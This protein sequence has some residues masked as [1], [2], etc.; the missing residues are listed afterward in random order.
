M[1]NTL[2]RTYIFILMGMI[3]LF[4]SCSK[5]HSEP[6]I[7][8]PTVN[9]IPYSVLV[10]LITPTDKSFN[11]Q[12]Y[13]AVKSCAL[14][15]QNWYKVQMNNKTFVLNPVVVDTLTGL[16][17]SV[18]YNSNN[19]LPVGGNGAYYNTLYELQQLLGAK[20]STV[21]YTYFVYVAA[22]FPDETIPKG[23]A[24]EGLGNLTGLSGK[25]PNSWIGAAGH[26]LGHAFGLPEVAIENSQ[27]IMSTGYPYYPNCIFTQPE[28]DSLNASPFFKLF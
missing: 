4:A 7:I 21:N 27:A 24:A 5:N 14:S 16:H 18:W 1:R 25:N 6:L 28:K 23:L 15:L 2:I 13:T 3:F 11:P 9:P 10:Y 19:G 17:N 26:A 8:N 12:Y 20:F 22:D